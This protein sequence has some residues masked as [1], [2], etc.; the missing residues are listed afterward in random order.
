MG[1]WGRV[2]SV[3]TS[4]RG[5]SRTFFPPLLKL[6]R[7]ITTAGAACGSPAS[8]FQR[9]QTKKGVPGPGDAG[10][11]E[12]AG[13]DA[14]GGDRLP[15]ASAAQRSV[16]ALLAAGGRRQRLRSTGSGAVAPRSAAPTYLP[17]P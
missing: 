1:W 3:Q 9:G 4:K 5:D 15:P 7:K 12:G 17:A 8:Q 13:T 2:K 16:P 10:G 14:L 6:Q 11:A